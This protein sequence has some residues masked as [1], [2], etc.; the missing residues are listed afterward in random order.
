MW[1]SVLAFKGN[2]GLTNIDNYGDRAPAIFYNRNGFLHFTNA[3][4]GNKNYAF[5]MKIDLR[6]YY[7]IVIQQKTIYGKVSWR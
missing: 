2:G 7:K 1:T 4:S 5:D 6:K 3:V